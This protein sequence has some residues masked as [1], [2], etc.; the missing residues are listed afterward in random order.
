MFEITVVNRHHQKPDDE[1]G[2]YIGRGSP[3]G[4]PWMINAEFTRER[5]IEQYDVY[6]RRQIEVEDP[7]VMRELNRLIDIA[8]T[9][10]LKLVCSCK[11]KA[12]H[13]DVVKRILLSCIEVE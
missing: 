11:P 8:E 3:L 5:A 4:N 7:D 13:G 9:R 10:P 6:L 1:K 12:C 2:E